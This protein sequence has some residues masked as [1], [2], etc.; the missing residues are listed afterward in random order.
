MQPLLD[1]DD[2]ELQFEDEECSEDSVAEEDLAGSTE[3]NQTGPNVSKRLTIE[4]SKTIH[5]RPYF[6][7]SATTT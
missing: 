3:P 2:E 5:S 4:P 6:G 7:W 1:E